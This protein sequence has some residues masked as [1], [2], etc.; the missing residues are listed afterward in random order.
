[1]NMKTPSLALLL[2]A[3][4]LLLG[5]CAGGAPAL[6]GAE[7]AVILAGHEPPVLV[8]VRSRREFAAGHLP[9]AL[10]IPFYAVARRHG[11][12][13]Q[14]PDRPVIVYCAHGP[15]AWWAARALRGKGF[16]RV[17]TL[18]LS[19]RPAELVLVPAD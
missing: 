2:A 14:D 3:L 15:R 13:S 17:S 6:T 16:S 11:E 4:V 12:I 7:M 10:H 8:D 19:D 9:G 1:M 18:A 5:G